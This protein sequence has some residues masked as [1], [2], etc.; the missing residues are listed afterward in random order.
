MRPGKASA[1]YITWLGGGVM[2]IAH[3]APGVW[4]PPVLR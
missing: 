4:V 1:L 2:Q 3:G